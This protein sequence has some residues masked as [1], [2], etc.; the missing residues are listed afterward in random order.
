MVVLISQSGATR[1][2]SAGKCKREDY[3]DYCDVDGEIITRFS[4]RQNGSY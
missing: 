2:I 4:G 1:L 3:E